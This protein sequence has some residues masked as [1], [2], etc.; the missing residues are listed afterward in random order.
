MSTKLEL[1]GTLL[2]DGP[3]CGCGDAA[4]K[5]M[6]LALRCSASSFAAIV[7]TDA[8][9]GISTPGAVGD[10]WIELPL[11]DVLAT[12]QFLALMTQSSVRLRIGAEEAMIDGVAGTYPTTFAGSE[13][14]LATIDGASF[15]TTFTSGAQSV[16]QVVQQINAAAALAGFAYQPASVVAGQVH[17]QGQR[18]GA[19]GA[20]EVTGGSG[21]ARLGLTGLS[22]VG[23][24][25]DVDVYGLFLNE[26]GQG[27]GAPERIQISGQAQITLMAA[28]ST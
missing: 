11:S 7:S 28:G 5:S 1:R 25:S 14:L 15:T 17:L 13:T 16:Q 8:A 23:A 3:G 22:A 26:W 10:S 20:A 12:I 21:A 6:A 27:S 9:I 18:T 19:Q 2:V 24:G 4:L